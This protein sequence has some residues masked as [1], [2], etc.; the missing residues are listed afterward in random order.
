MHAR[1]ASMDLGRLNLRW[2]LKE[3]IRINQ[4]NISQM[5]TWHKNMKSLLSVILPL[6]IAHKSLF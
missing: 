5:N 2:S 6:D 1:E 4:I 3:D